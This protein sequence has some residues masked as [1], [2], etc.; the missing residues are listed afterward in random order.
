MN[1]NEARE[2]YLEPVKT[3]WTNKE[4][5]ERKKM[6]LAG[7]GV[8]IFV[9]GIVLLLNYQPYTVLFPGLETQEVAEVL[10]QLQEKGVEAK[11]ENGGT[12]LVP[13]DQEAALKM[14]LATAGYPKSGLSYDLF[15]NNVDMMATDSDR[16]MFRL[17]QL[18]ERLQESIKTISGVNGAIVTINLPDDS[19]F[20]LSS[21]K[22]E[23]SA[24]VLVT[25]AKGTTL[26]D[27]Q[28]NGIKQLVSKSLPNMSA[29]NVTVVDSNT[30]NELSSDADTIAGKANSKLEIE[31]QIDTTVEQKVRDI[32]APIL[33]E[34]NVRVVA[35]SKVNSDTGARQSTTYTPMTE[36][37]TTGVTAKEEH[38]LEGVDPGILQ[39]GIPGTETNAE[40]T[41]VYPQVN[42]AEAGQKF[43]NE[44]AIDY[45][46]NE[47]KEEVLR[48]GV[49][50]ES[51]NVGIV[52]NS[53]TLGAVQREELV[54]L[55]AG[56]AGIPVENVA[57]Y[58]APFDNV[59]EEQVGGGL[60]FN[61]LSPAMKIGL[62]AGLVVLLLILILAIVLL[63]RKRRREAES[64]WEPPVE[65]GVVL[66]EEELVEKIEESKQQI[67][68]KQVKSFADE[69]PEVAAQLIRS[70]LREEDD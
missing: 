35:T 38:R 42:P 12:I 49:V 26:D 16:K 32:L 2:K 3:F 44:Y 24:S 34:K 21:Q 9:F 57:I 50:I 19:T 31:K 54:N 40:G 59:G 28:V 62:I 17:Y 20:V 53:D 13:K 27:A 6:I 65:A 43:Y 45:Y 41:P 30:G 10:A 22:N 69:H 64:F 61:N 25:L 18:E 68:I 14:S 51:I 56:T 58:A 47:T 39:A 52:I 67:L 37:G 23:A 11:I 60:S 5:G 1:V 29:E 66:S 7:V 70:W 36:N 55:V 63:L 4:P 33:G 15:T 46:V 8:L 48:Q